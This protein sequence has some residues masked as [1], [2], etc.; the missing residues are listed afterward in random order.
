MQLLEDAWLE[1]CREPEP[2][3]RWLAKW[4][5]AQSNMKAGYPRWQVYSEESY[6]EGL[7]EN[8]DRGMATSIMGEPCVKSKTRTEVFVEIGDNSALRQAHTMMQGLCRTLDL[9][10]D[11]NPAVIFSGN[12][13][14]HIHL[15]IRPLE[16]KSSRYKPVKESVEHITNIGIKAR[17]VEE[18][19]DWDIGLS[20]DW[21]RIV[22]PPYTLHPKSILKYESPRYVIPI[23][24]KW[25]LHRIL[26]E[27]RN[28]SGGTEFRLS[29]TDNSRI[30]RLLKDTDRALC[31]IEHIS[32]IE[33]DT[34]SVV[35]DTPNID[36]HTTNKEGYI[37]NML[38]RL[39]KNA[40]QV[41]DG[42]HRVLLWLLIPALRYS[43]YSFGRAWKL[44]EAFLFKSGENP[45]NF[46][47][48]AVYYWNRKDEKG[49]PFAPMSKR[50]FL[51]RYP[52]LGV[53]LR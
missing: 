4:R 27:A 19:I 23:E 14:F 5:P 21:R 52:D 44:I 3:P 51:E 35:F 2:Y 13:S 7:Y 26:Q 47:R 6:L 10:F 42:Q 48:E 50:E 29:E 34:N 12:K 32:S 9:L 24:P 8:K 37:S 49:V 40:P 11:A 41:R 33:A 15:A 1:F 28:P 30:R 16:L 20:D 38:R 53:V 43:N 39:L 46:Y 22:R 25:E 45:S 31:E 17:L 18:G 36:R